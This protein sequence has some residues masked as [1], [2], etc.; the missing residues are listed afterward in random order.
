LQ[1]NGS[2]SYVN[3]TS[4]VSNYNFGDFTISGWFNIQTGSPTG[5]YIFRI[6]NAESNVRR[7]QM[8]ESNGVIIA[9]IRPTA[10]GTIYAVSSSA[11]SYNTWFHIAFV[12]SNSQ[13]TL[14]FNGQQVATQT[15]STTLIPLKWGFLGANTELGTTWG[16]PGPVFYTGMA[17][18][19]QI[20]TNALSAQAISNLMS[21]SITTA[22]TAEPGLRAGY[23]FNE[24]YGTVA[25]DASTNGFNATVNNCVWTLPP[26]FA[27]NFT[28]PNTNTDFYPAASGIQFTVEPGG[29]GVNTNNIQFVLN[30]NNVSESLNITNTV[31]PWAVGYGGAL[32]TNRFYYA[33]LSVTDSN[34]VTVSQSVLFDTFDTNNFTFEAE[35]F[36]FSSGQYIDNPPIDPNITPNY[37]DQLGTQGID[38]VAT[39][40]VQPKLYRYAETVGTDISPDILRA[41]YVAAGLSDYVVTGV[42][43][44]EWLNYTRTFPTGRFNVFA[45]LASAS[46]ITEEMDLVTSDPTQPNQTT[47]PLGWFKSSSTG[48]AQTYQWVPLRDSLGN[49][50]AVNFS[51]VAT[52]SMLA[53]SGYNANFYMLVPATAQPLTVTNISPAPGT[54]LTNS[55]SGLSFTILSPGIGVNT[56]NVRVIING[57]NQSA[58]LTFSGSATA[59]NVHYA[60]LQPN[61][62]YTVQIQAVDNAGD[63]LGYPFTGTP[64]SNPNFAV[65]FGTFVYADLGLQFNG[66]NSYLDISKATAALTNLGDFTIAGWFNIHSNGGAIQYLYRITDAEGNTRRIQMVESNG[67]ITADFRPAAG[68]GIYAVSSSAYTYGDWMHIAFVRSGANLSLYLNGQQVDAEPGDA[69]PFNVNLWGYVGANTYN[70]STWGVPANFFT[71]SVDNFE[72]WT[73]AVAANDITNLM[74][75]TI[76]PAPGLLA[77]WNFNQGAGVTAYDSSGNNY[78]ATLDNAIWTLGFSVPPASLA[79]GLERNGSQWNLIW[80]GVGIQLQSAPDISG[81]WTTIQNASSPYTLDPTSATKQ[82]F[83][84]QAGN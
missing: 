20:R 22:A 58:S 77:A 3:F 33:V 68:G 2:S 31:D 63:D 82:F 83:R 18:E 34:A 43:A 36:N 52:V 29:N 28:S 50:A 26:S 75:E 24:R 21:Q 11:F 12:R 57:I 71:G 30:S 47:T 70:G 59:L 66:V 84:L 40:S 38:E 8:M 5:Q 61:V 65:T 42:A 55:S 79:L 1:F 19:F 73:N 15:N 4:A 37:F 67:L 48:S 25:Y 46:A 62:N 80:S 49:L 56:T 76:T 17:D 27:V 45:R 44:G 54:N 60:G 35:D 39:K 14:Y 72:I 32:Q 69:T 53:Q 13:L 6:S 41:K 9:D 16:K 64:L 74:A 23:G 10:A 78:N 51:G 7:I 81:P